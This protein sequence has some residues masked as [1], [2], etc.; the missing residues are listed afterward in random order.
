MQL[1]ITINF[2]KIRMKLLFAY[3]TYDPA[4]G[5]IPAIRSA[6][7]CHQ[8][9]DPVGISMHE[10]RDRHVR[11]F[12]AGIGHLERGSDRF[13]DSR[14]N[15]AADWAIGIVWIDEVEEMRGDAKG[16]FITRKQYT[17]ALFSR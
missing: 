9:Q 10:S 6:S 15:L 3:T 12:A 7:I 16:E 17:S 1:K 8:E 13:F 4:P 14:D 2:L 11:I 5:A